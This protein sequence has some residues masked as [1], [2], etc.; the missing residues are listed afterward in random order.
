MGVTAG[1]PAAGGGLLVPWEQVYVT[2]ES[3]SG[4]EGQGHG[5]WWDQVLFHFRSLGRSVLSLAG[6]RKVRG[7]FPRCCALVS[8]LAAPAELPQDASVK[9]P[10][11]RWLAGSSWAFLQ[12]AQ[13]AP[14]PGDLVMSR[15]LRT[16]HSLARPLR[17]EH[18][19][20]SPC[21]FSPPPGPL[22]FL[23]RYF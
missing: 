1:S 10:P 19:S 18:P 6:R 14:Q 16:V 2:L 4:H 9:A 23:P 15:D 8:A 7:L 13:P 3:A 20:D 21:P 11:G 12:D 5:S 17:A 22:V